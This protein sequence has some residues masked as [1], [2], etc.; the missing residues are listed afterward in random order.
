[1]KIYSVKQIVVNTH[2]FEGE[3]MN[4]IWKHANVLGE[5]SFPWE[6]SKAPKTIFRALFDATYF[7]F[8]FD[9]EDE[10]VLTFV[11]NNHKMEVVHSDRVEIFF[12]KNEKLDPYYCLEM[13]AKGRVLDYKTRYYRDF[14]YNW[15][16][17]GYN[18]M[19]VKSSETNEGYVVEGK[20]TLSSLK[21]LGLLNDNIL[22]AGLYRGYCL[23]LPNPNG[24]FKW[25][26]W[27]NP[28]V[29]KPDF[30]IPSSFGVLKFVV[31]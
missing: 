14:E 26:S 6:D 19:E 15:N 24:K 27:I 23:R 21:E 17:P 8:R 5:F 25:I 18:N 29:D 7:Y 4:P 3:C 22:Q 10:N 1:M 31:E 13:D 28:K 2:S 12:R 16:W 20:I 30:H 11:K 9:V